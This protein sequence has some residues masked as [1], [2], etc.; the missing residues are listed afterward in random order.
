MDNQETGEVKT[1]HYFVF[2]GFSKRRKTT[3][4]GVKRQPDVHCYGAVI[5]ASSGTEAEALARRVR[6]FIETAHKVTIE[7][8]RR[9]WDEFDEESIERIE[10]GDPN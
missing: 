6:R 8:H 9:V 4:L 10:R 1:P 2:V 3:I 5:H 7:N